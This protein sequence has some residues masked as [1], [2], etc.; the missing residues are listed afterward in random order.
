MFWKQTWIPYQ[1][2]K[3]HL[4]FRVTKGVVMV[5]KWRI[6]WLYERGWLTRKYFFA[7]SIFHL[8]SGVFISLL[9]KYFYNR[10]D[11]MFFPDDIFSSDDFSQPCCDVFMKWWEYQIFSPLP[12]PEHIGMTFFACSSCFESSKKTNQP[13]KK[14]NVAS[15]LSLKSFIR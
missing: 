12:R 14:K 10:S 7:V 8:H 11:E 2:L 5:W 15:C 1:P 6:L 9:C 4:T 13:K 3:Y